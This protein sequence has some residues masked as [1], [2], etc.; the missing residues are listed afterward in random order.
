M[1]IKNSQI[2]PFVLS[3]ALLSCIFYAGCKSPVQTAIKADGVLIVSVDTGMNL[4]HDRVVAGKAT[5]SQVDAVHKAY[6]QYYDAQ[7]TAKAVIE[8]VLTNVSTNSADAATA[9]AAVSNAES[10]LI[11]L[12]NQYIK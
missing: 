8:K 5:Q 11:S 10:S 9:N 1:K 2:L 3:L 6:N 7:M 4:W 12:L